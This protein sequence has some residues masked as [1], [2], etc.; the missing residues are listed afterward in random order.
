M[1]EHGEAPLYVPAELFRAGRGDDPE[2]ARWF[3][4]AIGI[5]PHHVRLRSPLPGPLCEGPVGLRLHLPLDLDPPPP[6]L[7]LVG[8]A[9]ETVVDEGEETERAELRLVLLTGL[10]EADRALIERYCAQRLAET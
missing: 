6:P 5:C 7:Q 1:S 10:G 3:R 2:V 4:L 9:G 8:L